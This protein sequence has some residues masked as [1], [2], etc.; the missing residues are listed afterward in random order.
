MLNGVNLGDNLKF[1]NLICLMWYM[2]FSYVFNS[3]NI[4][5]TVAHDSQRRTF[6][7]KEFAH[8]SLKCEAVVWKFL[9]RLGVHFRVVDKIGGVRGTQKKQIICWPKNSVVSGTYKT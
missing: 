9:F 3:H 5:L 1:N 8:F 4:F 2:W 6:T 7:L